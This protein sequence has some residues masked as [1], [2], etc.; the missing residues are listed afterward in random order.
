MTDLWTAVPLNKYSL[1][2]N[3]TAVNMFTGNLNH[4]DGFISLYTMFTIANMFLQICHLL[5][6]NLCF[7]QQVHKGSV[8]LLIYMFFHVRRVCLFSCL[9]IYSLC[10]FLF[11]LCVFM[12]SHPWLSYLLRSWSMEVLSSKKCCS[13][14]ALMVRSIIL[15]TTTNIY[16]L[17]LF[18]L[19]DLY[20]LYL[21][22]S[23]C[24]VSDYAN[25]SW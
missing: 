5:L 3:I 2:I 20:L 6:R 18:Y 21:L 15:K 1:L 8:Q 14:A 16:E 10:G 12:H 11:D 7:Y 23:L 4:L 9:C 17:N 13:T 24:G 25:V 22:F 19:K